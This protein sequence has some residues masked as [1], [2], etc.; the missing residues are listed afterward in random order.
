MK[1]ALY[2]AQIGIYISFKGH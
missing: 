2:I 1:E